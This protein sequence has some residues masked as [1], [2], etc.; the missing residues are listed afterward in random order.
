MRLTSVFGM[1]TGVSTY[2]ISTTVIRNELSSQNLLISY[3]ISTDFL[4]FLNPYNT[5]IYY[6]FLRK[7][8]NPLDQLV[9][10]SS[11]PYRTY[12]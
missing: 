2:R 8:I 3:R 1:G 4:L 11:I 7:T 9:H 5:I 12:T 6:L 10:L